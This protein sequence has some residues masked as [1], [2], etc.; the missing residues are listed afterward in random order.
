MSFLNWLPTNHLF[1]SE[2]QPIEMIDISVGFDYWGLLVSARAI[3]RN[4]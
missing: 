1:E 4:L 2:R 3:D